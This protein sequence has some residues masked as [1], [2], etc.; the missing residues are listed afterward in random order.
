VLLNA[1]RRRNP[2]LIFLKEKENIADQNNKSVDLHQIVVF[3]QQKRQN[4][5]ELTL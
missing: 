1:G 3:K 4:I 5:Q 2:P